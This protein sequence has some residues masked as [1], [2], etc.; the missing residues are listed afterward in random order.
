MIWDICLCLVG[1]IWAIQSVRTILRNTSNSL[2]DYVVIIIYI[3]NCIPILLNLIVGLPKY[4]IYIW[5]GEFAKSAENETVRWVYDVYVFLVL[6]SVKLYLYRNRWRESYQSEYECS[7]SPLFSGKVL[8]VLST[9]PIILALAFGHYEGYLSF[10]SALNRGL[11]GSQY[12]ILVFAEYIGLFAFY[13]WFFENRD[14]GRMHSYLWLVLYTFIVLWIDGKRYLVPTVLLMVLYFYSKSIYAE[15]KRLHLNLIIPIVIILFCGFFVSY[16]FSYKLNVSSSVNIGDLLYMSLRI[17]FGRDDVTKFVL[18][19]E[20]IENNPI[21]EYRGESLISTIL[22]FIPRSM[23]AGKPYPHYRY[24]TAALYNTD[25][26][27]IPAG[28]TPSI[29]EMNIANFGVAG[30]IIIT[31]LVFPVMLKVAD[32]YNTVP[33]KTLY[34]VLFIGLLTQSLDSMIAVIV[35]LVG[36]AFFNRVTFGGKRII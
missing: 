25:V 28:M 26:L 3:F 14:D 20:L 29:F 27:S 9:F 35:L 21:L 16:T 33:M 22:F 5:F 17:D 32:K 15:K 7:M 13:C 10:Q 6:S 2:G 24:L 34:L 23:W 11:T 8:I 18:Y 36:S 12:G 30:G 4:E 1:T 31:T 19:R